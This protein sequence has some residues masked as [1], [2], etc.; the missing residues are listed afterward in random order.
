MINKL[1]FDMKIEVIEQCNMESLINLYFTD[2]DYHNIIKKFVKLDN[3]K[4]RNQ[5]PCSIKTMDDLVITLNY[6]K[7]LTEHKKPIVCAKCNETITYGEWIVS[8]CDCLKPIILY[9]KKSDKKYRHIFPN[10]LIMFH[11]KCVTELE[12]VNFRTKLFR[13]C[14]CNSIRCGYL[15]ALWS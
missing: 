3:L 2:S 7:N 6:C 13:C 8:L 1:P 11:K 10:D 12:S 15:A 9:I 4:I 14:F 5:V